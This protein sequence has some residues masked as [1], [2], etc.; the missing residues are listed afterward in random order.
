MGMCV[1]GLI[2]GHFDVLKGYE[3]Q[4]LNALNFLGNSTVFKAIIA[5]HAFFKQTDAKLVVRV[6]FELE[7]AAVLH[8]LFK[9]AWVSFAQLG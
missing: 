3:K 6:V 4:I 2:H 7:A 8:V 5:L 9:L 1:A